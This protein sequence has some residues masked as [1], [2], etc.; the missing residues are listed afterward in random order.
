VRHEP[1]GTLVARPV[2]SSKYSVK[3]LSQ[4]GGERAIRRVLPC[5]AQHD[6]VVK[7][8]KGDGHPIPGETNTYG[9]L[10]RG[11][12]FGPWRVNIGWVPS[13]KKGKEKDENKRSCDKKNK[14]VLDATDKR[15]QKGGRITTD[16]HERG[17]AIG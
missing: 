9:A 12:R 2:K 7:R 5:L 4:Y 10:T 8:R 1:S 14:E 15:V 6:P 16:H 3:K 11:E 17:H 13:R